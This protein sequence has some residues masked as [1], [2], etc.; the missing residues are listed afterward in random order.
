MITHRSRTIQERFLDE[1][2]GRESEERFR[3]ILSDPVHTTPWIKKVEHSNDDD[4]LHNGIDYFVYTS[5]GWKIPVDVKSSVRGMQKHIERHGATDVC[6]I[7]MNPRLDD[8]QSRKKIIDFLV[9]WQ[10]DAIS[11]GL[12]PT[13]L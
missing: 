8:N 11:R 13:E 7:V 2:R 12:S 9:R 6:L 1:Q 3:H 4:D 10:E 5:T